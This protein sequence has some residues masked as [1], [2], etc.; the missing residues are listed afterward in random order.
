MSRETVYKNRFI[1]CQNFSFRL[2]LFEIPLDF[3]LEEP[4]NWELYSHNKTECQNCKLISIEFI[5]NNNCFKFN[6]LLH[7]E[8]Y[9]RSNKKWRSGSQTQHNHIQPIG[10]NSITHHDFSPF[11]TDTKASIGSRLWATMRE[12]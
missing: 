2:V 4:F 7:F 8:T 5:V 12:Q 3:E 6:S 10:L 1:F 11:S 9:C